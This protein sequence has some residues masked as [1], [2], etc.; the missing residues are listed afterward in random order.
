M[1]PFACVA[2]LDRSFQLG[3][4][5]RPTDVR[6]RDE[7]QRAAFLAEEQRPPARIEKVERG[8]RS[9]STRA[10]RGLV[11][12]D[13]IRPVLAREL[14]EPQ[15]GAVA[16]CSH[17]V[18]V[19]LEQQRGDPA[20]A[21]VV[22]DEQEAHGVKPAHRGRKAPASQTPCVAW[23]NCVPRARS[24]RR[25]ERCPAQSARGSRDRRGSAERNA[26]HTTGI[27][28]RHRPH[29]QKGWSGPTFSSV[30]SEEP[31]VTCLG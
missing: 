30:P 20:E 13:D 14:G 18:P 17:G 2:P 12:E 8:H 28:P 5:A 7:R 4:G 9:R 21:V 27:A 22:R 24:V 11:D 3:D 1:R 10:G 16:G 26:I 29:H 6:H 31:A 15:R 23:L 25:N 19:V